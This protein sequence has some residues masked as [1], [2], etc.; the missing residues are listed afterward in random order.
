MPGFRVFPSSTAPDLPDP[1]RAADDAPSGVP[2]AAARV[3]PELRV[4]HALQPAPHFRGREALV[5]A[6][7]DWV[8]D[9]ASPERIRVLVAPA[10]A[11]K[12]A[13]AEQV[14]ARLQR[15]WPAPGAGSVLVWSFHE[16]PEA[17]AFLR[18]CA[19]LFLGEDDAQPAGGR[20]E[21]L[22][23][24]LLDG[25]P[26]LIVLDAVE[27]VQGAEG[28]ALDDHPL[29]LLLQAVAAGL[30]RTRVLLT[31]RVPLED[32]REWQGRGVVDT[33]LEALS[34]EAARQVLRGW[35]VRGDDAQLDAVT[36]PLGCHA[37]SVAVAGSYL[38]HLE[39][40]RI[41]AA[42]AL[43]LDAAQGRPDGAALA[44]VLA[45]YAERLPAEERALLARMAVLPRGVTLDLLGMLA[46]AGGPVTGALAS[47][48]PRLPQ[49]LARLVDRGLVFRYFSKDG[50]LTWSAHALVREHCAPALGCPPAQLFEVVA[51]RLASGLEPRPGSK[52]ASTAQLDRYEQ[53]IEATRLAGRAQDAFD[54]YWYALGGFDH[55]GRALGECV[56]GERILRAFL[57]PSGDPR[58]F[59][60]GLSPDRQAAGLNSLVLM[61]QQL[62]LLQRAAVY[63]REN[64]AR[65]RQLDNP[66]RASIGLRMA[67]LLAYD[68]GLLD[69]AQAAVSEAAAEAERARSASERRFVLAYRARVRHRRGDVDGA[70]DDFAAALA[71]ES[72]PTL[73]SGRGMAHARHCLDLGDHAGCRAIGEAGLA[74]AQRNAWTTEV[75]GW[76][77]LFARLALAEGTDP[78][79]HLAAI[80]DWTARSGEM[81]WVVEA[82][83]I[84]ACDA[85]ARGDLDTAGLEARDG[86]RQARP[87]GLRLLEIELLAT[88]S[89][90][91]LAGPDAGQ[92]LAAARDALALATAPGCGDAW[93][94]ADAAHACGLALAAL[95][96]PGPAR[97]ALAQALAVRERIRHPKA[98]A[99]RDALARLG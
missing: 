67:S 61:T 53:L 41:E 51:A 75:P 95:N 90:I 55:L 21:R 26:R 57:P 11:G 84:A 98:Q 47:A 60:A 45:L 83:R 20:L 86:L 44:Q 59:G 79:P 76:Q 99:T 58:G 43:Q 93:G 46:E 40:G 14:L 33:A 78:A 94:E 7:S 1:R 35:G 23:R 2:A 69:E 29:R 12:T 49:L 92:A 81:E 52:P 71:L 3:R 85:L 65:L 50:T 68:L 28:G 39:G 70:R 9:T 54:L 91:H 16:R 42:S 64:D 34:P 25:R 32:L 5:Q 74:T 80:R 31:S 87:C 89:A 27:R 72:K 6:L 97:D 10:G 63:R 77:A 36:R 48:Q 96:Q 62:G 30:G 8:D 56:R 24:G 88:L 13:T 66:K 18:E 22:R 73:F 17:D 82:H 15:R 4:V 38:S 19:Q 37:L